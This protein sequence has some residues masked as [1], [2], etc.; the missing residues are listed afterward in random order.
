[1][2]LAELEVNAP[3]LGRRDWWSA[4]FGAV[5]GA[6]VFAAARHGLSD[7]S[8]IT[9]DYA[10]TLAEHGQWGMVGGLT[11]NTATSPL[12]VWLLAAGIVAT[13]RPVLAMGALLVVTLAAVGWWGARLGGTLGLSRIL[14]VALVGLLA[15][16]PLLVANVGLETYLGATLLV[17]VARYAVAGRPVV[18]GALCGWRCCVGPTS[19]SLSG[20]SCL[21]CYQPGG[22]RPRRVSPSWSRRRGI[23][24]RGS[25]LARSSPT[26]CGSR[27]ART[28]GKGT[29]CAAGSLYWRLF[30]AAT[31]LVL[32]AVVLGVAGAA[33]GRHRVAVVAVAAGLSHLAVISAL[34]TPPYAWYFAPLVASCAVAAAVTAA[35]TRPAV[36]ATAGLAL[37]SVGSSRR[38]RGSRARSPTTGAPPPS[39]PR[40]AATSPPSP[41][42]SRWPQPWRSARWCTSA[43]A[44]SST[45]RSPTRRSARQRSTTATPRPARSPGG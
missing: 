44:A 35:Q 33:M 14:P 29:R 19:R 15:T 3:E 27:P 26:R 5:A 41:A 16:S 25:P 43:T 45:S 12:N 24:G 34:G 11:S 39:T 30:P 38:P 21:A 13:G 42:A 32:A 28:P 4:G 1:M 17:G 40:L 22:G 36:V 37:A 18:T 8:Y 20:C 2:Q 7:D 6:A 10:R 31:A 23:C 9:L